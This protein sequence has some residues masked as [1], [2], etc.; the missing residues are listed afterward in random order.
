MAHEVYNPVT[1]VCIGHLTVCLES[2]RN[3]R[4]LQCEAFVQ[5]LNPAVS[6]QQRR[7]FTFA[8]EI[9]KNMVESLHGALNDIHETEEDYDE[10]FAERGARMY[11]QIYGIGELV[12][13]VVD[14]WQKMNAFMPHADGYAD[15]SF[16][17]ADVQTN[18]PY[19]LNGLLLAGRRVKAYCRALHFSVSGAEGRP[20]ANELHPIDLELLRVREEYMREDAAANA[21]E[22]GSESGSE[23]GD[24]DMEA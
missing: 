21:N 10:A 2:M 3:Y 15:G 1:N 16:D 24:E 8:H 13:V 20:A 9:V 5:P 11:V 12:R 4:D 23:S 19:P 14:A 17:I 18:D 7:I 6:D 22:S